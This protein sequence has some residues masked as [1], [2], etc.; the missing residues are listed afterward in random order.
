MPHQTRLWMLFKVI[1]A[2]EAASGRLPI[3]VYLISP[4]GERMGVMLV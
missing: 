3:K 1:T 2:I 4:R